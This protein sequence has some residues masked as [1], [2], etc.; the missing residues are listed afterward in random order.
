MDWSTDRV[1]S[2]FENALR[3]LQSERHEQLVIRALTSSENLSSS[4]QVVEKFEALGAVL[5][6]EVSNDSTAT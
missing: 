5:Q 2:F 3:V 6:S 1:S 4:A